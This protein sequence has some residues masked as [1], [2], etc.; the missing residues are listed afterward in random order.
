MAFCCLQDKLLE[1][2]YTQ[3]WYL[4]TCLICNG[5]RREVTKIINYNEH[6]NRL[7][8]VNQRETS[9]MNYCKGYYTGNAL[10]IAAA[11]MKKCKKCLLPGV[12]PCTQ[13][14][15]V[16]WHAIVLQ[17]K[18]NCETIKWRNMIIADVCYLNIKQLHSCR[19]YKIWNRDHPFP[20][21]LPTHTHTPQTWGSAPPSALSRVQNAPGFLF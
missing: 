17:Q 20:A 7:T 18:F 9:S 3:K 1:W 14:N 5:H 13:D 19:P 21:P 2:F 15:I 8:S 11:A 4:S 12:L 6:F 16:E 10:K